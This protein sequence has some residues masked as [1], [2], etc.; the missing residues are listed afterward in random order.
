MGNFSVKTKI[1]FGE[2]FSTLLGQIHKAFLVADPYMVESGMTAYVTDSLKSAGRE[3]M[4]FSDIT[5]DPDIG[6]VTNGVRSLIEFQPDTV[7]CFGG[8]SAIDAAKAIVYFAI[9]TRQAGDPVFVAIPTTSGTGSEVS[10]FAVITDK[11]KEIKYPLTDE[12]LVPDIAL[13]DAKLVLSV[14]PAVTADT[15]LDVLTH[16]IEAF[17]SKN[18]ND[19]T[20]AMAE[21]SIK[22]V[23]HNLLKC[24]KDPNDLDA[25]QGMHN[26]SCLAGIAFSNA[27]LGLNHGMAHA[28]GAHFHIAH[29]RANAILLPYVTSF[30]AGCASTL[31]PTAIRY[32]QIS[33]LLGLEGGSIRQSALNLIRT[34]RM[35]VG[36]MS[37]P[38]TIA[39]AGIKRADFEAELDEMVAS[40]LADRCTKTNPRECTADDIRTVFRKAYD[41]KLP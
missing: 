14:P 18:R 19:F 11:A 30:N 8:G 34:M 1:V 22:L 20:D 23:K 12:T 16:G 29:G 25:R 31:S 3:Y 37:M 28:L 17:V 41:G 32:A 24:Y 36:K 40:A 27:G 6:V 4:V 9:K 7:I 13:L 10:S 35:Y 26:A 33:R 21:K 5:P 2:D 39:A 38:S 15:G